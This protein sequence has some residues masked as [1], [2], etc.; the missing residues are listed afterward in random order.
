LYVQGTGKCLPCP[1][2]DFCLLML[3]PVQVKACVESNVRVHP[4][5]GA[6]AVITALVASGLPTDEF[7]F[8]A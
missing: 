1:G 5:P 2:C 3:S 6:S 7:T 8:G 4:I